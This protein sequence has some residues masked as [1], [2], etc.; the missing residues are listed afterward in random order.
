MEESQT[1]HSSQTDKP[2]KA[3]A[4]QQE[5]Q[6]LKRKERPGE[7]DTQRSLGD[8]DEPVQ[9]KL[10]TIDSKEEDAGKEPQKE[11]SAKA[12]MYKHIKEAKE[13]ATQVLDAATKEQAEAQQEKTVSFFLFR[14]VKC[15]VSAK[16]F[17]SI[18]EYFLEYC[19]FKCHLSVLSLAC[20][21]N[22]HL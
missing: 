14:K 3:D 13:E 12:E 18:T 8:V 19:P 7:S 20:R 5:K 15:Q 17:F 4:S 16:F 9:K 2:Q 21:R 6:D 10:K 22:T 1:G 11:D